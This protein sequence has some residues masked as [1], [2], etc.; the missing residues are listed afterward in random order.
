MD[1]RSSAP[2]DFVMTL[3]ELRPILIML[4]FMLIAL[5]GNIRNR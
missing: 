3:L 2:S 5:S 4:I 1:I